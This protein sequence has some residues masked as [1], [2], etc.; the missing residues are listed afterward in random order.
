MS[1][2]LTRKSL[3]TIYLMAY[4]ESGITY[5]LEVTSDNLNKLFLHRVDDGNALPASSFRFQRRN[6][7]RYKM[8]A[9]LNGKRFF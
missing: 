4:V 2:K 1:K 6:S 5:N 8:V 9:K 7:F 3:P